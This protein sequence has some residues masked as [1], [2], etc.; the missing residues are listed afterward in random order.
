MLHI[1]I[2]FFILKSYLLQPITVGKV[3]TNVYN[4]HEI[5]TT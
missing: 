1:F 4:E 3:L 5:K 2:I